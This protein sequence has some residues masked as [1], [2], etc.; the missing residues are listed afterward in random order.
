MSRIYNIPKEY[1]EQT[2]KL[3]RPIVGNLLA[4]D[5]LEKQDLAALFLLGDALNTYILARQQL[6]KDGI[7]LENKIEQTTIPG[8]DYK[9]INKARNIRPHPAL[10]IAND[11]FNQ[12]TRLLIEFNLTPRSRKKPEI[13]PL[14]EENIM[15]PESPIERFVNNTG[16]LKIANG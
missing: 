4:N 11:S 13:V 9:G 7:T 15:E 5:S 12:A 6:L 2:K 3:L 16:N 8:M 10:R 14:D 1:Q